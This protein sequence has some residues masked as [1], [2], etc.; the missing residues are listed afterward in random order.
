MAY[1][2]LARKYRPQRFADVAGQ[3]H[4][5][6]T[7]I[8]ALAQNRI[9]HGYI[10][11]GHRGIGKTTI[12]RILAMALNCRNAIGS[13]VRPTPEPCEVCESCT[14]IRA[15]NAVDVIEIDAATNRGID[16]I[17]ELRDA[18]RYRPARDKYKIYILDEAHQI[19]D[20]AFNAL[21]KTLE[22]PPDHIVFMMATT[23][24]EDI[25]QTVRSR[26]QHFSFHAVKLVDI[27]GE[28]R[29]IAERE[30]V[31][32]DESA[33]SLLAEAG[34]GSMRDAL[35]IMDQAI[36]SAPIED[37]RPRLDA[38]QIREL[39]GTVPNA[40]FEKILEAVDGN[41][42]AEVITVANQLLDAGNSPAQLARQFVRYL[43]N[44]V[45]A[46]IAGIGVDGA[47]ADGVAGELLQISA[48]EQRRA[49]R[50][51]ALFT[52][53]EL[54][55]FLQVMLRTFDEL[56]YRQEQRFHFE[57][58]LLKLVHLR[59]L[60]PIE[61]V[62]S[63]FPVAGGSRPGP[64]VATPR[65]VNAPAPG[66]SRNLVSGAAT[67][68]VLDTGAAVVS[69]PAFSPFERDQNKRRFD[70]KAVVATPMVAVVRPIAVPMPVPVEVSTPVSMPVPAEMV[71]TEADVMGAALV[72]VGDLAEAADPMIALTEGLT[73]PAERPVPFPS[74]E[75][76]QGAAV[77][78]LSAAKNQDTATDALADAEWT[79]KDGEVRVQTDLS[80]TMLPM[81][82]NGEAEKLVKNALRDAGAGALKLVLLPGVKTAASPKK[83]RAAKSG[84]A[85]AKAMDHPI[86][87][88]AQTL[89]NAE[90]RTVIDL[91][92]ND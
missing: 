31:D 16:E 4:V 67:A 26:C 2:V 42:S 45:I 14:E 80:K 74:A 70:E 15:G 88:R 41:R 46:K 21:L 75:A 61:E 38:G 20:A 32:A 72:E 43:R 57:L 25:P 63:Q 50:S 79:V 10:F 11:S 84:S 82:I 19:T 48:D 40:V 28:L 51:A 3:D 30:G 1:Q 37:G 6:V 24:P 77:D 78:A 22:E 83:P 56:G 44:T 54:T 60:L 71:L 66:P 35:S 65:T 23:Q 69:K 36:A 86:V 55:R 76:L 73:E 29:G 68:R 90:I 47:G 12:A 52:E 17:R 49:G 91:R 7:L 27:L 8:N 18:A 9:A 62:L 53:E 39:M 92:E 58:G 81:V 33:L 13:A 64:G 87:Q 5:T 89:F 85:Q 59:R 34:D